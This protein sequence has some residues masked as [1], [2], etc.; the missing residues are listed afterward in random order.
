MATNGVPLP[1]YT[2]SWADAATN[3]QA[4]VDA[5]DAD[6]MVLVSNGV[7]ITATP[8]LTPTSLHSGYTNVSCVYLAKKITLKSVNGP[9]VTV[10]DGNY[11]AITARCVT[12]SYGATLDGFTC[13]NGHSFASQPYA[14]SYGGG[15]LVYDGI[16]DGNDD[17]G[18]VTNCIVRNNY[19]NA[20]GIMARTSIGI[21]ANCAIYSNTASS[22]GGGITADS[23]V[24]G[25][26]IENCTIFDNKTSGGYGGG[27]GCSSSSLILRNCLV[28]RNTATTFGG[29]VYVNDVTWIRIVNLDNCTIVSNRASAIGGGMFVTNS[30]ASAFFVCNAI[31]YYNSSLSDADVSTTN[32]FFT[33]CCMSVTNTLTSGRGNI[34]NEP[35]FVDTNSANYRLNANSPCMNTGINREWMN[36]AVDLDGRPRKC[37]GTVDM[38]AYETIYDGT[39]FRFH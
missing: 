11:N 39:I 35:L 38:G 37:Y 28:Y 19:G 5:A 20:G 9:N 3:I 17:G 12:V 13:Q 23:A 14:D 1:P 15:I 6:D 24:S 25:S 2:N 36:G 26:K 30:N 10:I 34:I 22:G 29:G 4:A 7:Y 8:V 33:N 32:S 16:P 18:I 21:V 27:I 31:I